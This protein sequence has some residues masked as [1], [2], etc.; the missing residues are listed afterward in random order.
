MSDQYKAGLFVSV[1]PF[2][3][4]QNRRCLKFA[5]NCLG[6]FAV[7][8]VACHTAIGSAQAQQAPSAELQLSC[9]TS[10]G[11]DGSTGSY[12]LASGDQL[13][14]QVYQ[15]EDLSGNHSVAD[16]GTISLPLLGRIDA[17]GQPVTGLE[18]A[19]AKAIES[20]T[21]RPEHVS[22]T[23]ISR[24]P[25]YV[26]GLVN[27]PGSYDYT[28]GMSV[29]HAVALSG[30]L[31]RPDERQGGAAAISR[32]QDRMGQSTILLKQALA[33]EARLKAELQESD[34]LK[35]SDRLLN[36]SNE[37]EA[38]AYIEQQSNIMKKRNQALENEI[39]S[40]QKSA[41]LSD[42]EIKS[43]EERLVL[44]KDQID[45]ARQ[46]LDAFN[47]LKAQGLTR[48]ADLFTIHR[49]IAGLESD[50]RAVQA[51]II[52]SRRSQIE[53]QNR[54]KQ[55]KLSQQLTLQQ[56]L[57][58]TTNDIQLRDAAIRAS[59]WI[60]G[61]LIAVNQQQSEEAKILDF[62]YQIVRTLMQNYEVIP[63]KELTRLCPGDI[64][65]VN[66]LTMQ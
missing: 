2:V 5:S 37:A 59:R 32:E 13:Q 30:G 34:Q 16:D 3:S 51:R 46:E 25:I 29:L 24:K 62:D 1:R 45:L 48:R 63:A 50:L 57:N 56:E 47:K 11:N 28:S 38:K 8:A 26:V 15:R 35:P 60:V 4:S 41:E 20:T 27:R 58:S 19:I 23:L 64:V 52:G 18:T 10:N 53:A 66:P 9:F 21:G 12:A 14:V 31:F 17:R 55:L 44:I 33:T 39:S 40:L 43:L 61:D 7:T 22:V 6:F 54:I 42:H 36:I 49:V 65:R